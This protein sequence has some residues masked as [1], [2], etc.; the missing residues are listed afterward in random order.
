MACGLFCPSKRPGPGRKESRAPQKKRFHFASARKSPRRAGWR[1]RF[2]LGRRHAGPSH[3]RKR[4]AAWLAAWDFSAASRKAE[5]S[6]MAR[7]RGQLFARLAPHANKAKGEAK[8][9]ATETPRAKTP[10]SKPEAGQ[11]GRMGKYPKVRRGGGEAEVGVKKTRRANGRRKGRC[12]QSGVKREKRPSRFSLLT[13]PCRPGRGKPAVIG[14]RRR[15][16]SDS[17]PKRP[18]WG[19]FASQNRRAFCSNPSASRARRKSS[20]DPCRG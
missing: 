18:I 6:P 12:V 20:R 1:D 4:R 9:R 3:R 2:A 19:R 5:S 17:R 13:P 10:R 14:R 16:R 15:A 11:D 8:R 7:R